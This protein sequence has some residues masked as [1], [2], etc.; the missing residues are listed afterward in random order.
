MSICIFTKGPDGGGRALCSAFDFKQL[1]WAKI[2]RL[3]VY[4]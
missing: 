1:F 3:L 2:I 4:L